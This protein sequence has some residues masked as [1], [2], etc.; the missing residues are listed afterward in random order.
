MFKP[1]RGL[2]RFIF[3]LLGYEVQGFLVGS[4]AAHYF[5]MNKRAK[6]SVRFFDTRVVFL[7]PS[8][9]IVN[10][11]MRLYCYMKHLKEIL[12]QR[13]ITCVLDVGGH[14]G[15]FGQMVRRMGFEG[16]IISFEPV[17][18]NLKHLWIAA[19]NDPNWTVCPVSLGEKNSLGTIHVTRNSDFSSLLNLNKF[20]HSRFQG[21]VD[22]EENQETQIVRLDTMLE[23]LLK[24]EQNIFLKLDTQGSDLQVFRGAGRFA[25]Q[26]AAVQ[27]EVS[28]I[29]IYEGTPPFCE[30]IAFFE[31]MGYEI[32]GF[33][34]ITF[35][36]N[37]LSVIE[38]DCMLVRR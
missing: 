28:C 23:S 35:K 36:E 13:S 26:M 22:V 24:A 2:G 11:S 3:S 10:S 21:I 14:H 5:L 7:G 16:R 12:D 32:S 30:S 8:D 33:Y 27:V 31:S 34:P 1:L 25:G 20:G 9:S 6:P 29:P 38:F 17:R 15:H 19:E 18:E 37:N 4:K